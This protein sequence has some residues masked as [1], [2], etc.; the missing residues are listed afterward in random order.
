[1]RIK[2]RKAEDGSYS[3]LIHDEAGNLVEV[4]EYDAR[5]RS[6]RSSIAA[7]A[8]LSDEALVHRPS[9]EGRSD[10][11]ILAGIQETARVDEP[12][13]WLILRRARGELDEIERQADL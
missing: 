11:E 10:E 2:Q 9:R 13:A 12:T 7:A 1:V 8:A 6:L 4:V 3:E 5:G